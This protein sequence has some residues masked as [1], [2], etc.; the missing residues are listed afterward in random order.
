MMRTK[1]SFIPG[2]AVLLGDTVKLTPSWRALVMFFSRFPS[3]CMP[4][5]KRP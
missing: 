4:E 1:K 3:C 2:A 5:A